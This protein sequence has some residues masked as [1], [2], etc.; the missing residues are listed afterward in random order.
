MLLSFILVELLYS[1]QCNYSAWHFFISA[2][3]QTGHPP[4]FLQWGDTAWPR[5]KSEK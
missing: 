1:N 4:T 2:S 3:L 5:E